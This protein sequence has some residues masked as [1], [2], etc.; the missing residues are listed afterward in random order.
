MTSV[1]VVICTHNPSPLRLRRVLDALRAQTLPSS[2][3]D[4]IVIDNASTSPLTLGLDLSWHPRARVVVE[5]KLGLTAARLRGIAETVGEVVVFVDDDNILDPD[6]LTQSV[7]I[8]NAW[9]MLGAWGGRVDPDFE[10]E[11]PPWIKD[12]WFLLAISPIDRPRWSN[13]PDPADSLPTGAGQCVRRQT[14]QRYATATRSD[15][16]RATLD[17]VGTSLSSCGD[18]DLALTALDLGLGTGRFPQLRLRHV[19]PAGRL[20]L[21]YLLNLAEA[22]SYSAHVMNYI[23]GKT[24]GDLR[25]SKSESLFKAWQRFRMPPR[26]REFAQAFAWG[27]RRAIAELSKLAAAKQAPP[28]TP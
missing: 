15:P 1:S 7:G 25:V 4:L 2:Q 17:R 16:L 19:I 13:Q 12:Y 20:E 3:W 24:I 8:A 10:V 14:A 11:P 28:T 27:R 21:P 6:Y 18:I 23:R 26:Q 9:P 5:S 22:V